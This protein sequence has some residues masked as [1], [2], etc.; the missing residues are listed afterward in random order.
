MNE[1]YVIWTRYASPRGRVIRHA[2][3]PYETRAKAQT[4]L[5]AM[6]RENAEYG[7]DMDGSEMHVVK[8][9]GVE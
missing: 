9:I 8:L 1:Q 2:Y 3:G 7:N 5:D 4:A 6:V